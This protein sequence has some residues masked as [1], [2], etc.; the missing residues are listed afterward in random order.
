M[1]TAP[2]DPMRTAM[3]PA[4][5]PSPSTLRRPRAALALLALLAC[6]VPSTSCSRADAGKG[7][8]ALPAL[9]SLQLKPLLDELK[10]LAARAPAPREEQLHEAN[11]LAEIAV[12]LV[13]ADE[14]TAARAEKALLEHPAAVAALD[15]FLVH[16]QPPVR[17]RAAWLL[18]RTG[19]PIAIFPLLFRLKYE[20]D[21]E[22]VYWIAWS[23]FVHGNDH[24]IGWLLA[25]MDVE[26]TAQA[27]G[28]VAIEVCRALSLPLAEQPT[29]DELRAHLRPIDERWRATGIGSH[30][31][32]KAPAR[33][34]VDALCARHLITTEGGTAVGSS[35]P[36]AVGM[37]PLRPIDEARYVLT[38]TGQLALPLLERTLQAA[39]PYLRTM[40]LQV[41]TQIGQPARGTAQSI[42][43]LLA[44]PLT[45][46][47]AIDALGLIGATDAVPHLRPRLDAIE[48]EVRARAAHALGL[49][50]DEG[51]KPRLQAIVADETEVVDVRVQAAFALACLGD[52]AGETYLAA[53]ERQQD[54]DPT[55]L[56]KL[57]E[58][59]QA[60]RH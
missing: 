48:T 51:A 32:A 4:A 21:A 30:P 17:R 60:R 16:E 57:R 25:G 44:D 54:Y 31:E 26:A 53:R 36:G 55:I 34:D 5:P 46:T 13:D 20:T 7:G 14:R 9:P 33:V 52:P 12:Q 49:L 23:L 27:A 35:T 18:G 43:P 11:E 40:A 56:L 2:R 22:T 58:R 47:Y 1:R 24:G 28:T 42:L 29:Y 3:T 41:L 59:L 8:P 39:E 10:Q 37:I 19:Q 45:G 15:A 6:G 38:R 50:G